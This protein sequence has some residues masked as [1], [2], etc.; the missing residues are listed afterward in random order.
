MRRR[1]LPLA[2][3]LGMAVAVLPTVASLATEPTIEAAGGGYGYPFYWSPSTAAVNAGGAVTFKNTSTTVEHGVVWTGGPQT[4]SC[5][6]VPIN[7][8]ETNWKG[9]CTFTHPGTYSF[10][11]YVHPTEMTGSITVNANGTTTTTTTTTTTPTTTTSTTPLPA[12]TATQ[13]SPPP[14][15][16]TTTTSSNEGPQMLLGSPL[17]AGS[18]KLTAPGHGSSV[19][20]SLDVSI[21]GA[22]GRLEVDLLAKTA[23]LARR[24]HSKPVT[25][26]RFVRSSV[27]AGKV[28][29][30]VALTARGKSALR[31][32]HRL[33]LTVKITLTPTQGATVT[34][35]RSVVLHA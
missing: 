17:V 27:S 7:K 18:L 13:S 31:R 30:S 25:V 24:G 12:T 8:G 16:N 5:P 21:A 23:S 1:Y 4:P 32:H 33:A 26:G 2:A 11:C 6:G 34:I 20:G 28:S 14:A 15:G 10:H 19:R 35:T 3:V 22:G 9:T 29:F